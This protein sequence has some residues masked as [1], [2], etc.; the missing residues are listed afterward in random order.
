MG[1]GICSTGGPWGLDTVLTWEMVAMTMMDLGGGSV[2]LVDDTGVR[3]A[4]ILK[5][6]CLGREGVRGGGRGS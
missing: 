3:V 5:W 1:V 2:M 6:G 4:L